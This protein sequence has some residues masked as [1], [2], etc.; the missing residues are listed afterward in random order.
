MDAVAFDLM[1]DGDLPSRNVIAVMARAAVA[2]RE[3]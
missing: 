1:P 2:A 3:I